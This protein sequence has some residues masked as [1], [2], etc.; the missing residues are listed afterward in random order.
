ML[1]LLLTTMS[2]IKTKAKVVYRSSLIPH[3]GEWKK[4]FKW[5]I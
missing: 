4:I 3:F 1:R 5:K 2:S